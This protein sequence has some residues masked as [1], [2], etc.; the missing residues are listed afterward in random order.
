MWPHRPYG[1]KP[2]PQKILVMDCLGTMGIHLSNSF[3]RFSMVIYGHI[4]RMPLSHSHRR[5]SLLTVDCLATCMW[6]PH[7]PATR[8]VQDARAD[9]RTAFASL[10]TG[11]RKYVRPLGKIF[12][13]CVIFRSIRTVYIH[14]RR[15]IWDALTN[16]TWCSYS[17]LYPCCTGWG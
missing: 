10:R 2:Q 11:C 14:L 5:S 17:L 6:L 16:S 13:S 9:A 12:P 4:G 7:G 3:I 8:L 15:A 1:L